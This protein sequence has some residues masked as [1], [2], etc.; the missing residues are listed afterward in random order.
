[1]QESDKQRLRETKEACIYRL[2]GIDF[3]A[4]EYATDGTDL[5]ISEY[6]LGCMSDTDGHNLFELLAIEQFFRK[7]DKYEWR[8]KEVQKFFTFYERMRFSGVNGRQRY[9]LTPVQCFQFANIF[10]FYSDGKRL[11]KDVLLFVPRKYGKTTSCASLAVY[12]LLFGDNNAQAYVCANDFNQAKICFDEIRHIVMDFDPSMS[13]FK[14]NREKIFCK[15]A[16]RESSASCLTSSANTKDGLNASLVILD[17]YSQAKSSELR[18][19]L[20][21]SM[22]ARVQPLV[23]TIT[24]ASDKIN[25]PFYAELEGVK[26]VLLGE[27]ENDALFAH[28]FMP[29]VD[30]EESDERTWRKVQPHIG[31]TVQKDYYLQYYK[32]ALT[33]AD[34]MLTFRTKLLNVFA[35]NEK[36][37]WFGRD[38]AERILKDFK[39]EDFKGFACLCAFDLSVKDDFSA[40]CYTVYYNKDFYCYI[41]YYFPEGQLDTHP[42]SELYRA[43]AADGHLTLCKGKCIDYNQIANDILKVAKKV[44]I[45][46]IGYDNYK[47]GDL[48]S[49]LGAR[50]GKSYLKAYPQTYG[51]FNM[52]VEVFT[53]MALTDPPRVW[54]NNNPINVFCLT[55]AILDEDRMENKKPIKPSQYRKID[56]VICVLMTLGMAKK[57]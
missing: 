30:D 6:I 39:V 56:G 15:M 5:R 49:I 28:L 22:G 38:E 13:A 9:K 57:L 14:V 11:T 1:M 53:G 17:E 27:V 46:E 26:R 51:A 50:G 2:R 47:A 34:D 8:G 44:R 48:A 45:I 29:D 19:T 23:V 41:R 40:V 32:R 42:N 18:N 33:N 24:T 35:V 20:I 21:S 3:T 31:V 52:P 55:N 43:W 25:A 16:G 37:A 36:Q 10:G 4:Y 12:D 7:L 54:L